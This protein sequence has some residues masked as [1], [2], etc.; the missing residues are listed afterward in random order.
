MN[1]I[2]VMTEAPYARLHKTYQ[3]KVQG[4]VGTLP[5]L[6][7]GILLISG[8]LLLGTGNPQPRLYVS[9][10]I[11]PFSGPNIKTIKSLFRDCFILQETT[12]PILTSI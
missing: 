1:L 11:L 4:K 12:K 8:D 6:I 10:S 3:L 9:H 5:I 2:T 7:G